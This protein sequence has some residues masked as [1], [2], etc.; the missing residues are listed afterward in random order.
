M[1]WLHEIFLDLLSLWLVE[2]DIHGCVTDRSIDWQT[3]GWILSDRDILP[4]ICQGRLTW[5]HNSVLRSLIELIRPVLKE[6]FELF[7]DLPGFQAPHRGVI[8]P[9]I[10]VT[11]L[12]PG[13]FI[14]NVLT[15]VIVFFVLTCPW[16]SNVQLAQD[17]KEEKYAPL[18]AHLSR[19]F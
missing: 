3:D 19:N 17:Y 8:P 13:L 15:N 10:L 16:D 5:R 11:N 6:N 7:S 14:V 4:E 2:I 9:D 12:K 1:T 18:I